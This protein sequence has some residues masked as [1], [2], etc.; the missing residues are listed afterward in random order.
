MAKKNENQNPITV[1]RGDPLQS[2]KHFLYGL[3]GYPF[4]HHAFEMKRETESIFMVLTLGELVGI[5]VMPPIY[6]LR[7]LPYLAPDVQKWKR[8]LARRKEFWEKEEFDL[9]GV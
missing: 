2:M 6:T 7:L 5:P 8:Q 1:G 4:V 3:T 9:H